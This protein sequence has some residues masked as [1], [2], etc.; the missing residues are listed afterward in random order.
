MQNI[1]SEIDL[2]NNCGNFRIL[3]IQKFKF[4]ALDRKCIVTIKNM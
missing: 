2:R 1:Q 3:F 4:I